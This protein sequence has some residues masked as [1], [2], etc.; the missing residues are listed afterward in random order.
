MEQEAKKSNKILDFFVKTLNGMAYGLF[1]TLII[2]TILGT[3]GGFFANGAG[4]GFCDFMFNLIGDGK[5]SGLAYLLQMLTGAGIGIGIAL[6]LKCDPLKTIVL[7]AV[8]ELSAY[9]SLSAKFVKDNTIF[10][11]VAKQCSKT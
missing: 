5:G 7:G 8:D 10:T 1:A 11:N 6:A 3:I 2:G 9:L 4:N